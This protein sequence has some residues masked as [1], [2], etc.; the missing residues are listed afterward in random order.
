[1]RVNA[2]TE[3]VV[4]LRANY[5]VSFGCVLVLVRDVLVCYDLGSGVAI[6]FGSK[7]FGYYSLGLGV[8]S[9]F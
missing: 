2:S 5:S 9:Q 6:G 8:S 4:G 1:M 3:W 7:C